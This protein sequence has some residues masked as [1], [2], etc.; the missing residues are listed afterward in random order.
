MFAAAVRIVLFVR[1]VAI[2]PALAAQT[3]EATPLRFNRLTGNQVQ[4]DRSADDQAAGEQIDIKSLGNDPYIEFELAE[5]GT[6][7]GKPVLEF[8]YF[9][10][11]GV[12]G[13]ELRMRDRGDW[14]PLIDGGS[15]PSAQGWVTATLP[16]VQPG[17]EY[18]TSGEARILRIDFGQSSGTELKL[19]GL[20]TREYT[21]A[22]LRLQ[23]EQAEQHAAKQQLASTLRRY[24]SGDQMDGSI[25]RVRLLATEVE[26]NGQ[27]PPRDEDHPATDYFLAELDLH[28]SSAPAGP[29]RIVH[30]FDPNNEIA[31]GTFQLRFPRL[32]GARDRLTSRWQLVQSTDESD[33]LE[34][35]S[36]ARYADELPNVEGADSEPVPSLRNAKGIGG[37]SPVFGLDELIE[38]GIQHL[39]VNVVVTDL[40][41][42]TETAGAEPFTHQGKQW[43]VNA[44]R[45]EHVDQVAEFASRNGIVVAAILLLP[46]RSA[47]AI[48]HPQASSSGIY[49]MPNLTDPD[50]AA[51]YSA[52][53]AMLAE[54]YG[55]ASGRRIDHWIMHNEVDFGWVWTNMGEQPMEVYLD[56]YIRSMRTMDLHARRANPHAR[57]FISL[58]HHWDSEED[59]SWRTYSPRRMID[60]LAAIGHAEGDFPWGVA[61]HPYPQNLFNPRTWLDQRVTDDFDT[62]LITM[63]NIQVLERYLARPECLTDGGQRRIVLLSEQG[64]HTDGYQQEAQRLQ[65]AALLYTWDRLRETDFVYAYDY[66]RWVDAAG[67]GGLLLGLRT[68]PDDQNRAGEKKLGWHVYRAIQGPDEATWRERLEPLY[69]QESKNH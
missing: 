47:D 64:Y 59:S 43:W 37:V 29:R 19:R 27:F 5:S 49:A 31:A 15:L 6:R 50:A 4:I 46:T 44:A 18:W 69:R 21:E 20:R 58:T 48:V 1:L 24:V 32:D 23:A 10:V 63:K 25:D 62:P 60:F 30:R 17:N 41:R 35:V 39:T 56:H 66:H 53:V 9:S 14:E 40:L 54:R 65:G 26:I 52:V 51:R 42:E 68:L 16:L 57:V 13:I 33:V 8:E 45:L 3:P 12:Q 28:E 7:P 61:H 36:A 38:L 2:L 55:A 22:E 67:E 11:Q 34:P